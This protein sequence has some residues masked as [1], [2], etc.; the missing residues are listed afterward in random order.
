MRSGSRAFTLAEFVIVVCIVA[1]L[2][3]VLVGAMGSFREQG[4]RTRTESF[5]AVIDTAI[6]AFGQDYGHFPWSH[7]GNTD[8]SELDLDANGSGTSRRGNLLDDDRDGEVDNLL[9]EEI[10]HDDDNNPASFDLGEDAH[11]LYTTLTGD[12]DSSGVIEP[13]GA[14]MTAG[15]AD[16][17]TVGYL[18][19]SEIPAWAIRLD[20]DDET[21][22]PL[23]DS[24]TGTDQWR[25]FQDAWGKPLIYFYVRG[26]SERGV[27]D[28]GDTDYLSRHMG[29]PG[30]DY[31]PATERPDP[32]P[33]PNPGF[34]KSFELWSLG[35]DGQY[36]T[37]RREDLA[38]VDPDSDNVSVT[39]YE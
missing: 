22:V 1:L 9:V 14:D 11:A 2:A 23:E 16:D 27:L 35:P 30:P 26:V 31:D 33:H 19:L 25:Y 4:Y 20:V 3:G 12:L 10:W 6:R 37:F 21:G 15:N 36:D 5:L 39:P 28:P 17:E 13:D 24:G 18:P 7:V 8:D 34:E 29:R 38:E 32:V